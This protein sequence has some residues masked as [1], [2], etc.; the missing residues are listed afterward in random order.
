MQ[1]KA[2]TTRSRA[3]PFRCRGRFS[4][5]RQLP[6][7]MHEQLASLPASAAACPE[8]ARSTRLGTT[9]CEHRLSDP[10]G[11]DAHCPTGPSVLFPAVFRKGNLF[12]RSAGSERASADVPDATG[13]GDLIQSTLTEIAASNCLQAVSEQRAFE[14]PAVPGYPRIKSCQ[15]LRGFEVCKLASRS[16]QTRRIQPPL[17]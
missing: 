5:S 17:C 10:E 14:T 1:C 4:L 2:V 15:A 16:V 9:A 12:Q 8:R 11:R 3:P 7:K 13:N 6:S